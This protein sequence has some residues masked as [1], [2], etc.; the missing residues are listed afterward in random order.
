MK[1]PF[2]IA[3]LAVFVLGSFWLM[4]NLE[5]SLEQAAQNTQVRKIATAYEVS[6]RYFGADNRLKYAIYSDSI[7]EFSQQAGTQINAPIVRVL[8]AEQRLRWRGRA[9]TARLSADKNVL[10]L[11]GDVVIISSP[12]SEDTIQINSE[13]MVYRDDN[14]EVVGEAPVHISGNGMQQTAQHFR[15]NTRQKTVA[16]DGAVKASYAPRLSDTTDTQITQ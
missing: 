7:S 10:A 4:R 15:L 16:F 3:I 8:D 12:D 6:G 1:Q 14:G 13:R 2:V 5:K 11:D 9:E